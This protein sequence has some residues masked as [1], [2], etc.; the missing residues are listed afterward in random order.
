M[1]AS[2]GSVLPVL[3][4]GAWPPP[5]TA[6]MRHAPHYMLHMYAYAYVHNIMRI[7]HRLEA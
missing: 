3:G 1:K 2:S 6:P 4:S 5:G 7:H